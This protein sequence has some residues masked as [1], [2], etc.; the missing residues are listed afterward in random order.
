MDIRIRGLKQA[1]NKARTFGSF[2]E[3]LAITDYPVPE[4]VIE[5]DGLD[6]LAAVDVDYHGDYKPSGLMGE[7]RLLPVGPAWFW[8][9][10]G[11]GARLVYQR[12]GDLSAHE[13]AALSIMTFPNPSFRGGCT[14]IEI[15]HETRHPK[16]ARGAAKCSEVETTR[17]TDLDKARR[18]LLGNRYGDLDDAEIQEAWQTY[19]EEEELEIGRA[20]EHDRCPIKSDESSHGTPVWIGDYGIHCKHCDANG[21]CHDGIA[22]PGWVPAWVLVDHNRPKKINYLRQAVKGYCHVEHARHIIAQETEQTGDMAKIGYRALLKLWHLH[23][24]P[25]PQ[26]ETP[27]QEV[28]RVFAQHA[29]APREAIDERIDRVFWSSP[30]VRTKAGEVHQWVHSNNLLTPAKQTGLDK[31]LQSLPGVMT[32]DVTNPRKPKW[33]VS[34]HKLGLF[35][36]AFDLTDQGYPPLTPIQGIDF[37]ERIRGQLAAYKECMGTADSRPVIPVVIPAEPPIEVRPPKPEDVQWAEARLRHRFP[38][39]DLNYLRLAICGIGATQCDQEPEPVRV[40]V[41]GQSSAGKTATLHLAAAMCGQKAK[42]CRLQPNQ[43][44]LLQEYYQASQKNC[45][46]IFDETAK[47]KLSDGEMTAAVLNMQRDKMHH[48]MYV[49]STEISRPAAQFYADTVLP[50]V[51]VDDV[52]LARRVAFVDLGAGLHSEGKAVDWSQKGDIYEWRKEN[53]ENAK[54]ANIIV[55]DVFYKHF[56]LP[57]VKFRKLVEECGFKFLNEGAISD[58]DTDRPKRDLFDAV[59]NDTDHPGTG[60]YD[61]PGWHMVD[62]SLTNPIAKALQECGFRLGEPTSRQALDGAQWGKIIGVPG[63]ELDL[64]IKGSRVALRFRLGKAK[65]RGARNVIYNDDIRRMVPAAAPPPV[66]AAA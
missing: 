50:Q 49:G 9:T 56:V 28:E 36:G 33:K 62:P 2:A 4:P 45:I 52:Q 32:W 20:Y 40:F 59:C 53:K 18:L 43:E 24:P 5:W 21:T 41:K 57:T 11:G 48:L 7:M 13:I 12:Q 1:R 16:Y 15:K 22:K 63:V 8:I 39:I 14:G 30:I 61:G 60:M 25:I 47:Q 23:K 66:A 54:A 10:H 46:A 37:A 35:Q 42:A 55:S 38:G 64:D 51:F 34:A 26:A 6:E 27:Q 44:R 65:G 58:V 29:E 17:T 3:A 19:C 31:I